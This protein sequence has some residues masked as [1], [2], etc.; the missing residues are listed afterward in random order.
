MQWEAERAPIVCAL[1]PGE[2]NARA[3]LPGVVV[4]ATARQPIENGFWF[5]FQAISDVVLSSNARMI[6]A[7]D[8]AH[9]SM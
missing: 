6:D 7:E 1:Q 9:S 5:E 8:S 3:I 4:A 2:L